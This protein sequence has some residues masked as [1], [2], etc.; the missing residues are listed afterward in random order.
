MAGRSVELDLGELRSLKA[1]GGKE[2]YAELT[3]RFPVGVVRVEGVAAFIAELQGQGVP[4]RV[5][6]EEQQGRMMS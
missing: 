6:I 4:V 2:A 5:T 3:I 1:R